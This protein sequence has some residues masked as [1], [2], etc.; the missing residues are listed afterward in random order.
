MKKIVIVCLALLTI[1][2]TFASTDVEKEIE[3]L[4]QQTRALEVKINTLHKKH[5]E[6]VKQLSKQKRAYGI[7]HISVH[8]MLDPGE[9]LTFHP[10]AL[11]AGKNVL[12][13]I[14]GMP[15]VTS[16]YLGERPAFDGSDLIVN[17]SSINQDV[18]LLMQ[19]YAF[20][21]EFEK[22]GYPAPNSPIIALSG[23]V[24][25]IATTAK[26]FKGNRAWD[27]DLGSAELDVAAVINPWVE[28]YFSFS[29][30]STPPGIGG[31]R[32]SN[33]VVRL[34]KG[35][36]NIGNLAKTPVYFTVG[37]LYAPFGRYSSS[38]ISAPVTLLLSRT[39]A[40]TAILG[41]KQL[42][43]SAFYGAIY[44]FRS[45]TTVGDRG[46]GGVNFGYDFDGPR[47][48][49]EIGASFISSIDDAGGMQLTGGSGGRFKGFG[50]NTANEAVKK[51]PAVDVHAN[52]NV[53]ALAIIGEWVGVTSA[54]RRGDLSFNRRGAKPQA[55]N[56][57]GAYTFMVSNKPASVGLGY[58]WTKDGLALRLPEHRIDAVFNISI[59]RDTVESIEYRHDIDYD[60]GNRASGKNSTT[61][62]RGTG[63]TADT[64]SAQIGLYF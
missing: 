10:A 24:E 19:R 51:V 9:P 60:V 21:S 40:R 54:F 6:K 1:S 25:P 63:R 23:K 35:F 14:A 17:I 11:M 27:D 48:R 53:D 36:I 47:A 42:G 50:F 18:R 61:R 22:L 38:M 26:P 4:R 5:E 13:Y 20:M 41:F 62:N 7:Q 55:A 16:P 12:T 37:Q 64:V 34:N 45:D 46:V 49:G 8:T 2:S 30:D 28:G 39:R 43:P 56:I 44:G 32:L 57:E 31:Q 29:Y 52:F 59:W 58:G 15:V 33:S 3:Q